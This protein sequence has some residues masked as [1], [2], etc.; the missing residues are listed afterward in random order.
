VQAA[1][2]FNTYSGFSSHLPP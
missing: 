2:R 1:H